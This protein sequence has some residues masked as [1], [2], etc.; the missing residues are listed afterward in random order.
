MAGSNTTFT[1]EFFDRKLLSE[2]MMGRSCLSLELVNG[3]RVYF[4][5]VGVGYIRRSRRKLLSFH[6]VTVVVV[7]G[8]LVAGIVCSNHA[9]VMYVLSLVFI[10]CVVLCR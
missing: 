3:L 7:C 8:R 2:R 10:C 9:E 5:F 1:H 4:I 6:I